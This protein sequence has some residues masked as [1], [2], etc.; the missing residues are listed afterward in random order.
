MSARISATLGRKATGGSDCWRTPDRILDAVRRYAPI[1]C[2]P[3]AADDPAHH[4]AERNLTAS[5]DGLSC[6]WSHGG[7]LS[8]ANIPYSEAAE[9]VDKALSE[10]A[11]VGAS[12]IMLVAARPGAKWYR[13]AKSHADAIAEVRGRLTFVGAPSSAP[14]PSALF[15]FNVSWRR[16]FAAFDGIADCEVPR[17]H[18]REA[19]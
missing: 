9:W 13:K 8:Y 12:V 7:R 4:F 14:F 11:H 10:V 16:F 6:E 3:C 18:M 5:I 1:Y 15:G 19:A 17:L 2:D